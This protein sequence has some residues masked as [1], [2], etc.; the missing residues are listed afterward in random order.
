MTDRT[1]NGH[2]GLAPQV[3]V[4]KE[5]DNPLIRLN[6]QFAVIGNLGGKCLV[7][8]WVPSA[9]DEQGKSPIIPDL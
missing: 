7:L 2:A 6:E 3:F 9:V 4:P 5:E 1:L 8:D